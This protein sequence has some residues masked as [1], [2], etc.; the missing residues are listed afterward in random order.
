MKLCLCTNSMG[1]FPG[2]SMYILCGH[3]VPKPGSPLGG[4][5]L[6]SRVFG[7][8]STILVGIISSVF[9]R[10]RM[11]HTPAIVLYLMCSLLDNGRATTRKKPQPL[12]GD[13]EKAARCSIRK[14]NVV[15]EIRKVRLMNV[16]MDT[17]DAWCINQP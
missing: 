2:A 15:Q 7:R 16:E 9:R 5:V 14:Q 17:M 4:V 10:R 12:R 8:V 3:L 1:E 13:S 6:N 11:K